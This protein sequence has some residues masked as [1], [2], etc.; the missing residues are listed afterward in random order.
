MSALQLLSITFGLSILAFAFTLTRSQRLR[1]SNSQ[2]LFSGAVGLALMALG[3]YPDLFNSFLAIL[4]FEP[5]NSGR[6]IGLLLIAVFVLMLRSMWMQAASC[7]TSRTMSSPVR[8]W[9]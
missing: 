1:F 2:R 3:I 6:L 7:L 5:G 9:R 4:S 8:P